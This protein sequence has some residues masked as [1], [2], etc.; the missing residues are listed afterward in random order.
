LSRVT[1]WVPS[2]GGGAHSRTSL[3]QVSII[4]TVVLPPYSNSRISYY[5]ISGYILLSTLI[6]PQTLLYIIFTVVWP[7]RLLR[8]PSL[9]LVCSPA[10]GSPGSR[11][12]PAGQDI[13]NVLRRFRNGLEA[14]VAFPRPLHFNVFFKCFRCLC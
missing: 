9:L 10:G 13:S 4:V 7:L 6:T 8:H 1:T 14:F 3:A 5:P 12:H 2:Q 11:L